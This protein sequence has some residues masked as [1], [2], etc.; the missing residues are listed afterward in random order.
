MQL[1]EGV[2][3]RGEYRQSVAPQRFRSRARR[4]IRVGYGDQDH[5][6]HATVGAHTKGAKN[7]VEVINMAAAGLVQDT[8]Q[9]LLSQR[10]EPTQVL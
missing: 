6:E 4:S 7:D 9:K 5:A 10:C 2:A 8:K 3:Y 1:T